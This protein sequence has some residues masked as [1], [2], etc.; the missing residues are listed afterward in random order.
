MT[1]RESCIILN[2]ISGIGFVKYNA[3]CGHFGSASAALNAPAEELVLVRGI[4]A[5]LSERLSSWRES[6]DLAG[7]LSRAERGGVRIITLLDGDYPAVLRHLPDPPLVLYVK[8]EL[9]DFD[10]EN[11]VGVVGSRRASHYGRL[12]SRRLSEEAVSS[13][14]GT[15]SGLAYGIDFESHDATVKSGGRTIAVLGGGLGRIHPKE[16][17]PLARAIVESGGAVISE[18]PI[19]FPVNRNS[20]PRRNRIIAGL[21]RGVIVVEA[22]LVSGAMITANLANDYG[23]T[24]FAVPGAVGNPGSEG[25]HRLIK[26]GEA[27]LAESFL[28][29]LEELDPGAYEAAVSCG[30]AATG[31]DVEP[32]YALDVRE[33]QILNYLRENGES[34]FDDLGLAL[35]MDS[36]VLSGVLAGLEMKFL[37][38]QSPGRRYVL[39]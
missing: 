11:F 20:F 8:G 6:C 29:V 12:M 7:E 19:L 21:S 39:R 3:L 16:H 4:G 33:G 26:R 34:S 25:C 38:L 14:W 1:D 36:G 23:R 27:R 35:G 37:V 17:I 30:R 10:R 22:G 31:D 5:Q 28:D 2:M 9:P 18:F 13:G 24:V 15:V 32:D